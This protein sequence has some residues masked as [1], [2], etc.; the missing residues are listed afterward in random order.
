MYIWF[1]Y[2]K[3]ILLCITYASDINS[4]K[5]G[6][7]GNLNYRHLLLLYV[8]NKYV[9]GILVKTQEESVTD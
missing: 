4:C 8:H 6:A 9:D 7:R 3:N 2:H 1:L 5:G